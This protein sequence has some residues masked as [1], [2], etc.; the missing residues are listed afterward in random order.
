MEDTVGQVLYETC[1]HTSR[2]YTS[3]YPPQSTQQVNE[4]VKGSILSRL[5]VPGLSKLRE[6]WSMYRQP[7]K[8]KK[9]VSLFISPRG[10]RVAVAAG[11]QITILQKNDDYKE[12]CGIFS[13]SGLGASIYGAWSES[14]DVLGIV[15]ESHTVYFIKANGEEITRFTNKHLKVSLPIISLIAQDETDVPRSCLCSFTVLTSDGFLHQIE[16]SQ[17]P[18][19]SISS[20]SASSSGLTLRRQF[21]QNVIC[22][23]YYPE[24]SLLSVVSN[25]D[26]SSLTSSGNSGLSCISLWRRCHNLELEQLYTTQIEGLY[27][28]P[29]GHEV[30]LAHPKVLISPQGK[31]VATS[32]MTGCLYIFEM[33]KDNFSLSKFTYGGRFDL[34]VADSLFDG[35]TNSISDI[36]D[37]TWWSDN[38]LILARKSGI[39]TMIDVLS[40]LK[41]KE[42]DPVYA[43]LVLGRAQKLQG[44]VFLL[45][46]KSLEERFIVSN[47]DREKVESNHTEQFT[48]EI[49]NR[50]GNSMLYWSL[51]SFSERSVPEMYKILIS[52]RKYQTAIHF[53]SCHGLDTDEVLKS[54][55]LNSSQGTDEINMF[56]SKIKDPAF[57]LS[58]CVDKVGR[59]EDSVKALLA[60]GLLLTN[61]Y[62]FSETE[63][64]EYS[65]I[66]DFR[67]ARLQLL[68][69]GD[70]LE[71]YLGI[72]MGSLVQVFC[73]GLQQIP[74][75]AD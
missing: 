40:G 71:T 16:I 69:F 15:D 23:D 6:K 38:I 22:T 54:Q 62:N 12:P 70:R 7:R 14:H 4:G 9:Q 64:D 73:A 11:N 34:Q 33:D 59:T 3:N 65:Q 2:P 20:A 45:E 19:A 32:D 36:M 30:K 25:T 39:I 24:L 46:S 26:T 21:P 67:I 63:D 47:H 61:Q 42:T 29:K 31:F 43:M 41:V 75:Y 51:I 18:S 44:H 74:C 37:F 60:H 28:Q 13:C 8:T 17:D 35:G 52:N 49:F 66:W 50:C 55:W 1:H 10:E 48:E 53:A 27:C 58:E 72:N 56:L 68:Q 5:S 57:V